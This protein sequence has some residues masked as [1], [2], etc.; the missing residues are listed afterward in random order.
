MSSIPT[1]NL[2]Q[3]DVA[4]PKAY[5]DL[6]SATPELADQEPRVIARWAGE[7]RSKSH[8]RRHQHASQR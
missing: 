6:V 4:Q 3:A 7:S 5:A 8:V 1:T 2:S